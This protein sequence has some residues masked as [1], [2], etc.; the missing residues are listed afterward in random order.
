MGSVVLVI[1]HNHPHYANID[2]LD[3]LYGSRF[4]HIRHLAPF[5]TGSAPHVV[6]VY[7]NSRFFQGYVSQAVSR[8]V[9]D[10]FDHY[11]FVA[12]DLLLRPDIAE[13]TYRE[14]LQLD[15]EACFF[16][17]FVELHTLTKYWPRA[18]EAARWNPRV[19]GAQIVDLLPDASTVAARFARFGLTAGPLTY[20]Q[21]MNRQPATDA[22]RSVRYAMRYPL[23]G[24]YSDIF[25]VS[26]TCIRQF[27]HLCGLFAVGRLFV[28][29]AIPTAMVLAADAVVTEQSLP[30]QGRALWTAEDRA[31][32]DRYGGS[33]RRLMDE[34][35]DQHLYLHPIKLSHWDTTPWGP[36]PSS[37]PR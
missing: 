37:S 30:Y 1:I 16:P 31:I 22:E 6:P 9:D 18:T 36:P 2:A 19:L 23:I 24:G 21:V 28:E 29:L 13:G 4:R 15:S 7:E 3:R 10:A 17:G 14:R 20:F 25:V 12:D 27:A 26:R 32:L 34:F 11:L 33:L 35:P 5:Y 8:I